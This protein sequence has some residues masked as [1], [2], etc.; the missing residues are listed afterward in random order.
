MPVNPARRAVAINLRLEEVAAIGALRR[1]P[2]D[3]AD[4]AGDQ[5]YTYLDQSLLIR[6]VSVAAMG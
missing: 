1:I 2:D 4:H 3:R 5:Q 6:K